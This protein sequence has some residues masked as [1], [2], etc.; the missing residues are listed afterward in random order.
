M[1][2]CVPIRIIHNKLCD[3]KQQVN[4]IPPERWPGRQ[5][6]SACKSGQNN[7]K[8]NNS[9]VLTSDEPVE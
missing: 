5:P 7:S 9:V 3:H 1:C 8:K 6:C 2:V 4:H